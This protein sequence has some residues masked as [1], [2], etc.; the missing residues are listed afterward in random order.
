MVLECRQVPNTVTIAMKTLQERK[1]EVVR[2]AIWDAATDLFVEKGYD[3][4]TVE[5]IAERAGV[6]RR[7]F[8]RY[9]SSKGDLVASGL[10]GYGDILT[11]AIN[12]CP[13]KCSG[14]EVFRQTVFQVAKQCTAH[15]R[16]RKM[17]Q[18]LAKYPAANEAQHSRS[19]ELRQRVTAAFARRKRSI[20]DFEPCVLASLTL[21]VLQVIFQSWFEKGEEDIS[22][23]A[24]KVLTTIGRVV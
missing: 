13:L 15:H 19:V 1:H 24:E 14:P 5:D 7:S 11:E 9:F 8:F 20:G 17:M 21:A 10:T 22:D 2:S 23:T 12:G 3:E 6:S 18:I 4:T 16:A